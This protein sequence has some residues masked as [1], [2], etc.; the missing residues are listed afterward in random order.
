MSACALV[1]GEAGVRLPYV[2]NQEHRRV[3]VVVYGGDDA[4]LPH[5]AMVFLSMRM[6][7]GSNSLDSC[8]GVPFTPLNRRRSMSSWWTLLMLWVLWL[9]V[10]CRSAI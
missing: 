9:V 6:P 3:P 2:P 10:M 4:A 7:H 1:S 8:A 5:L